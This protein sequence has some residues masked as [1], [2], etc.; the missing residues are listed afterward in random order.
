MIP[1]AVMPFGPHK[2]KKLEAIPERYLRWVIRQ[3]WSGDVWG[4]VRMR[5]LIPLIRQ[6]LATR[7]AIDPDAEMET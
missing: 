6:H 4:N 1:E 2:G 3:N 7:Q 5:A